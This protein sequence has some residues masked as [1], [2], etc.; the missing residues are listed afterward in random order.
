MNTPNTEGPRRPLPLFSRCD[1]DALLAVLDMT[2]EIAF[3]SD[4]DTIDIPH[5]PGGLNFSQSLEEGAPSRSNGSDIVSAATLCF[6]F[7][8]GIESRGALAFSSE[9]DLWGILHLLKWA[10]SKLV[11]D[12]A[13]GIGSLQEALDT[14]IELV[15]IMITS[16]TTRA[17]RTS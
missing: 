14:F 2:S 15:T 16:K 11:R 8:S 12:V 10:R 5:L 9:T 7:T 13:I 3:L 6:T 4:K 17:Q 1:L